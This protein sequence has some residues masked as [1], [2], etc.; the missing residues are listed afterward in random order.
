MQLSLWFLPVVMVFPRKFSV[1]MNFGM[2]CILFSF[3][4]LR[5]WYKFFVNDLFLNTKKPERCIFAWAFYL[6]L[7]VNL[8][9]A[10]IKKSARL[11]LITMCIEFICFV[12]FVFSFF[13]GGRKGAKYFL[14]FVKISLKKYF[15]LFIKI[16]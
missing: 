12:Y 15:Q 6:S 5:G 8:Y 4:I 13:P 11:T 9:V 14:K 3:G 7:I 1:L 16:L 10:V 2:L